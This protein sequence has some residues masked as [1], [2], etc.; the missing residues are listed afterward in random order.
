MVNNILENHKKKVKSKV[1]HMSLEDKLLQL[2]RGSFLIQQ[3]NHHTS[4]Y[5]DHQFEHC[6]VPKYKLK[7]SFPK[8]TALNSDHNISDYG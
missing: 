2:L 5:K 8:N 4:A 3:V 6:W 7:A 1:Q